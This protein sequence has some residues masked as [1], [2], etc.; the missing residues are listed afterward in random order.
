MTQTFSCCLEGALGW[1]MG[2]RNFT[3]I[4]EALFSESQYPDID[5]EKDY[6]FAATVGSKPRTKRLGLESR[7]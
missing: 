2:L 6:G 3:I 1:K 5:Q 7:V 4:K